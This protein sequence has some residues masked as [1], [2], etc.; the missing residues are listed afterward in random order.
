MQ[1]LRSGAAGMMIS[2][3][4]FDA[5]RDDHD[6]IRP[7]PLVVALPIIGAVS[8]GLWVLIYKL[9]SGIVALFG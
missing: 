4:L 9:V 1:M 7:L 3:V 8:L 5:A 2:S 6:D